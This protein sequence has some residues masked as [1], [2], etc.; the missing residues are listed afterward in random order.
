ALVCILT[1]DLCRFVERYTSYEVCFLFLFFE[2]SVD[3]KCEVTYCR[4]CI[5]RFDVDCLCQSA[6]YCYIVGHYLLLPCVLFS[7][8]TLSSPSCAR[9][10]AALKSTSF[11]LSD[12]F[13]CAFTLS[14]GML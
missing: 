7:A 1:D 4:T 10:S 11:M 12:T 9:L 8:C 5:C 3:S 2:C 13:S 14:A 6:D